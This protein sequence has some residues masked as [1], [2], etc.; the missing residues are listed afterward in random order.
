MRLATTLGA[1]DDKNIGILATLTFRCISAEWFQN[2][3]DFCR[4]AYYVTSRIE[5]YHNSNFAI[6]GGTDNDKVGT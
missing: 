2:F 4:N 3:G 5:S 1:A 6:T